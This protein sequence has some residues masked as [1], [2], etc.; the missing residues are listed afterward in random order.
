MKVVAAPAGALAL[1][2]L[3][4]GCGQAPPA[5][6]PNVLLIS[7]DTLRADRLGAYGA[8]AIET[9]ALDALAQG[10]IRFE[11]A[12][13]PVPLTLPAHWTLHTGVEPWHHG[14]VDNGMSARTPPATLAERLSAI[15]YDS[16]AFVAAF[17]LHR[18]FGLDRGFDH[19]DDGP[20]TDA[21]LDQVVHATAPADERVGRALRWLQDGR[22][23][24]ARPFF[25]WL[26]LFDPHAPYQ[27]P[28]DF[29]ARYAGR[30]YDGE[31]AFVDS[32]IARLMAGLE[33]LGVAES[34]LIVLT[35]DHGESLGEHGE[36]THGVLLYEATLRVPLIV[37][38]PAGQNAGEVRTEAATLADVV[39]T[40]LACVGLPSG[41][42]IDG[43]DLFGKKTGDV[44]RLGAISE[45]PRRRL[46]WA[47]L[48]AVREGPFKFIAA[49]RPELYR[50][51]DDPGEQKNLFDTERRQAVALARGVEAIGLELGKRRDAGNTAE[52][53]AEDRAGL[54]ALG[55]VGATLEDLALSSRPDPKDVVGSLGELDRAYQLFAEGRFEEAE[56]RFR[57]LLNETHF[58]KVAALEGLARV[59]RLQGKSGEATAAYSRLLEV[60]PESVSALAQLILLARERGD[61][62]AALEKARRLKELAPRDAAASRLLA[63]AL[64][65]AGQKDAAEAEWMQALAAVPDAGWLRLSLARFLLTEG[66]WPEAR[67][68][69]DRLLAAEK[70]SVPEDLRQAATELRAAGEG[71]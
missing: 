11:N 31:V 5:A 17:V 33:R 61:S 54:A 38:L 30:P 27:P 64:V 23:R 6:R 53:D 37:R 70:V 56:Q 1:A 39:P 42:E 60:D 66:R 63:E 69:L 43:R 19:Y 59:A 9:P 52:P 3:F 47:S 34:T 41:P 25:L 49:P 45:Y 58:P 7:I 20:A 71:R 14:V 35:S 62:A 18:S 67:E 36:Q 28:K 57:Q 32:Q 48:V 10:G 13:T 16:A 8:R 26:H 4:S 21:A 29:R 40:L 46:G 24:P 12:F 2:L 22:Q 44:R 15:G 65:A 50:L 68:H 51:T 55:Y